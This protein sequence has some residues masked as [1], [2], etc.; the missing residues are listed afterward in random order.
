MKLSVQQREIKIRSVP[1]LI[2]FS[3]HRGGEIQYST[4]VQFNSIRFSSVD[5][6]MGWGEEREERSKL[7]NC[8]FTLHVMRK[9]RVYCRRAPRCRVS[10]W[11]PRSHYHLCSL[12][13]SHNIHFMSV[14][15]LSLTHSLYMCL[16]FVWMKIISFAVLRIVCV[17]SCERKKWI[18]SFLFHSFELWGV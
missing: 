7:S 1:R 15:T 11:L 4:R 5:Y 14:H 9:G 17:T 2:F 6:T 18:D 13:T 10:L 3:S 12:K 16:T 8:E